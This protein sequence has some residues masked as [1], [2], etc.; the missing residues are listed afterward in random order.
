MNDTIFHGWLNFVKLQ[1]E[2]MKNPLVH[3]KVWEINRQ[4]DN[5]G[6]KEKKGKM[7]ACAMVF[8]LQKDMCTRYLNWE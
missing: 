6:N 5:N 3:P 7:E 8:A 2:T 1:N 4:S